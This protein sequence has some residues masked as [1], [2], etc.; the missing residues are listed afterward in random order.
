MT[1]SALTRWTLYTGG[2]GCR[3][4]HSICFRRFIFIF[5]TGEGSGRG[6][7]Q[8]S[9]LRRRPA[10][11]GKRVNLFRV[12]RWT[13]SNEIYPSP[14]GS[15]RGIVPRLVKDWNLNGYPADDGKRVKLFRVP[16]WTSSRYP[17]FP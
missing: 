5:K 3:F 2:I 4:L 15:L 1:G 17:F 10:D 12:P 9:A 11:D 14:R 6:E 8:K 16:R 13:S 7:H